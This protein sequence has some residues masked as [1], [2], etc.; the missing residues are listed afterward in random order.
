LKLFTNGVPAFSVATVDPAP[1]SSTSGLIKISDQGSSS[2][3]GLIDEMAALNRSISQN[4]V[5]NLYLNAEQC[6][7]L[8]A[9][10]IITA[11]ALP[12]WRFLKWLGD[13]DGTNNTTSVSLTRNKTAQAIFGTTLAATVSGNGSVSLDPPGGVYPYGATV[14]LT[15]TPGAGSYFALWGNAA[16]GSTNP[17]LF[18]VTNA[19]PTVSCLFGT[20]PGN[21]FSLTIIESGVGRVTTSPAAN[22]FANGQTVTLTAV[23]GANQKFVGWSGDA[24]GTNS[25]LTVLMDRSRTITAQFSRT[26]SFTSAAAPLPEGFRLTLFGEFGQRYEIDGSTDLN[27]W[28]PLVVTTNSFGSAQFMDFE[29]TNFPYRFYRALVVP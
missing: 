17:L 3:N 20:L 13:A 25:P 11:R 1:P 28:T 14:R 9:E 27:S 10:A 4:E 22:R 29:A 21:Q 23:P 7:P 15:A 26:P 19:N 12:G 8:G 16:S 2:F 6:L 24:T 5:A 18:T